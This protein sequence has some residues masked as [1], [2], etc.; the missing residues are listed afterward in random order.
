MMQRC[1]AGRLLSI[2]LLLLVGGTTVRAHE[3]RPGFLELRETAPGTYSLLWKGPAGGEA[4][5]Y[6]VPILPK[7]CRLAT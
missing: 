2:A 5:I 4:P 6:V 1:A 7:D 3:V